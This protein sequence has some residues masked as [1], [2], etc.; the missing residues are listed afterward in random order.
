MVSTLHGFRTELLLCILFFQFMQYMYL[1]I[2][3]IIDAIAL[4][5]LCNKKTSLCLIKYYAK[6]RTGRRGT[7]PVVSNLDTVWRL[8]GQL[9]SMAVMLL[10]YNYKTPHFACFQLSCHIC[11]R[12]SGIP[13]QHRVLEHQFNSVA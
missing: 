4:T 11:F 13:P 2:I 12:H 8:N 6:R 1:S 7:A 3:T 10:V 5:I 9:H